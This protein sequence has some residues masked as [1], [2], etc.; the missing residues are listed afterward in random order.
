[1][2]GADDAGGRGH[3][4]QGA[5]MAGG[6]GNIEKADLLA[7][8][9][10]SQSGHSAAQVGEA[11]RRGNFR[12]VSGGNIGDVDVGLGVSPAVRSECKLL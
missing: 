4:V 3:C 8:R 9:G 2:V 10:K 1:M 6:A 7:I 12:R 11:A 5:R